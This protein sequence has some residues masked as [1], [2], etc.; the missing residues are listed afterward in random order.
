MIE[1]KWTRCLDFPILKSLYF[2]NMAISPFLKDYLSVAHLGGVEVKE[3][4]GRLLPVVLARVS[5]NSNFNLFLFL[6][7]VHVCLDQQLVHGTICRRR[8]VRYLP[9]NFKPELKF[10]KNTSTPTQKSVSLAV[11]CS[12][13]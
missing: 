7:V 2:R 3:G 12:L 11:I 13:S 5:N 6:D 4:P 1:E 8:V 9:E 10:I